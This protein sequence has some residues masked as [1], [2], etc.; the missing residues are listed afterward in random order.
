[1]IVLCAMRLRMN[2]RALRGGWMDRLYVLRQADSVLFLVVQ[3]V[4]VGVAVYAAIRQTFTVRR[5]H[6]IP[7]ETVRGEK[8]WGTFLGFHGILLLLMFQLIS[9]AEITAGYRVMLCLFNFALATYL[10]LWNGWFRNWEV[11]WSS[12]MKKRP[13]Q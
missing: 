9:V 12:K 10:T 5:P 2:T 13:E 3:A 4:V 8:S 11:G 1:M 7:A 6:G